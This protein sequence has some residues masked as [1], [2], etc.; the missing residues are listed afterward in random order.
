MRTEMEKQHKDFPF[1]KFVSAVVNCLK[2]IEHEKDL[3][4]SLCSDF[5]VLDAFRAFDKDA[6]GQIT[7]IQLI[8]G[9]LEMKID[10]T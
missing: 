3:L 6:K 4:Y 2:V 1:V 8:E 7:Q 5:N 9:F 10:H